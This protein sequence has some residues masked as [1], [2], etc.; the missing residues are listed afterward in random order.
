MT[1]EEIR[2]KARELGIKT[3]NLKKADLIRAIQH[4]EGFTSCFGRDASA[5][6]QASCC[7]RRECLRQ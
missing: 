5:C 7:W 1:V 6:D 3:A 2:K 4:A